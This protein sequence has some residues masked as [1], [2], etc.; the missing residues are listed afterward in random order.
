MLILFNDQVLHSFVRGVQAS[1][2][3]THCYLGNGPCD[4]SILT[5]YKRVWKGT[6]IKKQDQYDWRTSTGKNFAFLSC[7]S[8]VVTVAGLAC[9][10]VPVNMVVVGLLLMIAGLYYTHEC[11]ILPNLIFM[12]FLGES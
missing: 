3:L 1:Q 9:F 5:E 2:V 8:A 7:V 6:I 12:T 4:F 10:F 11:T